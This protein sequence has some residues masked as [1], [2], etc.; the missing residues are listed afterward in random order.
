MAKKKPTKKPTPKKAEEVKPAVDQPLEKAQAIK[1]EVKS[2]QTVDRNLGAGG[3]GALSAEEIKA[4]PN[5]EEKLTKTKSALVKK[6]SQPKEVIKKVLKRAP[7]KLTPAQLHEEEIGEDLKEIYEDDGEMPDM[8]KLERKPRRW[9]LAGIISIVLFATIGG[10]IYGGWVFWKPWEKIQAGGIS[11]EIKGPSQFVNGEKVIYK[12]SYKN[13]DKV[14]MAN[15][16]IQANLPDG[17]IILLAEPEPTEGDNLWQIGSMAINQEG[18]IKLE[19]YFIDTVKESQNIQALVTYKPANFSSDFQGI[20]TLSVVST[21]SLID[22][23]IDGPIKA[24]PGDEVEYEIKFSNT[25]EFDYEKIEVQASYPENFIFT[26]SEPVAITESGNRWRFEGLATGTEEIIKVRG[27]FSSQG[28]GLQDMAF[29]LGFVPNDVFKLQKE[30]ML[31]TE[32]LAG[33]LETHLFV[34]GSESSQNLNFGE[35]LRLSLTYDNTSGANMEDVEFL[36]HIESDPSVGSEHLV[37]W[38]SL[39]METEREGTVT[40]ETIAWDKTNIEELGEVEKDSEGVIDFSIP[41]VS[42]PLSTLNGK[43]E[44]SIWVEA[45]VGKI[46]ESETGREI[47]TTP[48][49]LSLNTDLDFNAYGR[50]FNEEGETMGFGPLPPQIDETTGYHIFWNITNSL[51]EIQN[52]TVKATLPQNISWTG[53]KQIGAGDLSYNE[54][55][56]EVRWTINRLPTSIDDITASFEVSVRPRADEVGTFVKL[57]TESTLEAQDQKT[58]DTLI[59]TTDPVSTDIPGDAGAKGKGVVVE[60]EE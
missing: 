11:L 42:G 44:V 50:Y 39:S 1:I 16:E 19:G 25:S 35:N 20:K 8:T 27:N 12:I 2:P 60:A 24:I 32:V 37:K 49:I 52:I 47:Q 51:H 15:V 13:Q 33:D 4:E 7:K 22:M 9:W 53:R 56:N 36:V 43:Y 14:P 23:S 21:D 54:S 31:Q 30:V 3:S 34:N 48:I 10:A 6:I 29:R 46:G 40:G 18:E 55:T 59:I 45:R 38:D 5:T 28:E 26:E 58:G 17:F 57:V 41:L